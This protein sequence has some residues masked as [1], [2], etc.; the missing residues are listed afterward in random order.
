LVLL[1]FHIWNLLQDNIT[2]GC[3]LFCLGNAVLWCCW[4]GD[5]KGIRP[6]KRSATTVFLAHHDSMVAAC[7]TYKSGTLVLLQEGYCLK[8]NDMAA[9]ATTTMFLTHGGSMLSQNILQWFEVVGWVTGMAP[10]CKSSVTTIPKCL[11]LGTGLTWGNL[12]WHNSGKNGPIKHKWRVL[13]FFIIEVAVGGWHI[14][15]KSFLSH[16]AHGVVLVSI[17]LALSQTPAYTSRPRIRG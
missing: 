13:V 7:C 9:H 2:L 4:L 1:S 5:R 15:V 3:Q 12:T 10:A 14:K 8:P 17:S 6:V 16:K 11:L